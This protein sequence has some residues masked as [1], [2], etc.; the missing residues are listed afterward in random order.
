M[1]SIVLNKTEKEINLT[2][3]CCLEHGRDK[4]NPLIFQYERW[5]SK[6][7]HIWIYDTNALNSINKVD[8]VILIFYIGNN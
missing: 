8:S 1:N 7:Y 4:F 3:L 2:L 5:N 6:R